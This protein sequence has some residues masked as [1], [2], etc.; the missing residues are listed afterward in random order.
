MPRVL[1][2]GSDL[3]QFIGEGDS[4][5]VGARRH[6]R[7][8]IGVRELDDVL[9][10]LDRDLVQLPLALGVLDRTQQFLF[11]ITLEKIRTGES[12]NRFVEDRGDSRE[13]RHDRKRHPKQRQNPGDQTGSEITSQSGSDHAGR[14]PDQCGRDEDGEDES[15]GTQ[16]RSF[17]DVRTDRAPRSR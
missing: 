11:G 12:T 17:T 10:H 14:E 9:E 8:D 5:D 4:I 16:D 13:R 2:E 6:D 7:A 15:P 3:G 1:D